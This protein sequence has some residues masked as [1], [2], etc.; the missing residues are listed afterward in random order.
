M[1]EN[2]DA[3]FFNNI[4][5]KE[6]FYKVYPD[7]EYIKILDATGILKEDKNNKILD[8][9][10]GSGAFSFVLFE[11]GFRNITGIDIS[12]KLIE[13][14][15]NRS[16]GNITAV[17]LNWEQVWLILTLPDFGKSSCI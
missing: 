11:Q 5:E 4:A 6:G 7:E 12:D 15:N 14:A 10:C 17:R 1:T 3:L 8:V 16:N 13:I 2:R 9:G